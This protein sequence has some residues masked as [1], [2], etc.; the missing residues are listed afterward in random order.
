MKETIRAILEALAAFFMLIT[1]IC[2]RMFRMLLLLALTSVL[3]ITTLDEFVGPAFML[4]IAVEIMLIDI[5][6]KSQENQVSL[7][8]FLTSILYSLICIF[9]SAILYN[10]IL[11]LNDPYCS[12]FVIVLL[13]FVVFWSLMHTLDMFF[14]YI[15]RKY[16]HY[17]QK[18][19]LKLLEDPTELERIV[20]K[21]MKKIQHDNENDNDEDDDNKNG[22]PPLKPA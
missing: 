10:S 8:N 15:G 2:V 4:F 6:E 1:P 9:F 18:D 3:R 7:A 17:A 19:S 12:L 16:Y 13:S 20:S 14:G 21:A 22:P 5:S 11:T